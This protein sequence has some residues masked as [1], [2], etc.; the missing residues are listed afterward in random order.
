[1]YYKYGRINR[2]YLANAAI[3]KGKTAASVPPATMISASPFLI[4]LNASPM[5]CAPAEQAVD[6]AKFGP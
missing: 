3:V 2:L 5:A 6:V 1:M 4:S